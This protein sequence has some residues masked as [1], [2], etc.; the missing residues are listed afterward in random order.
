M[1]AE[2]GERA[3]VQNEIGPGSIRG[4][5]PLCRAPFG[6]FQQRPGE[7]LSRII[8]F[9]AFFQVRERMKTQVTL[10]LVEGSCVS[11]RARAQNVARLTLGG[12]RRVDVQ[13]DHERQA[14]RGLSCLR[15]VFSVYVIISSYR[16]VVEPEPASGALGWRGSR[17]RKRLPW[18][19][20]LS[21]SIVPPWSR[22]AP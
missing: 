20:T 1:L 16:R 15:F 19:R 3:N 2:R 17:M 4:Q 9:I 13:Q 8:T 7:N 18:P 22:T 12:G 10:A 5:A 21:T 14:N 6:P 11:S